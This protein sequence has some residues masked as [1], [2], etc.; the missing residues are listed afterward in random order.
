MSSAVGPELDTYDAPSEAVGVLRR[1]RLEDRPTYD[2]D[3]PA[4][5]IRAHF[6]DLTPG[7]L[8]LAGAAA[9]THHEV[10]QVA[11]L[12]LIC[13]DHTTCLTAITLPDGRVV[14][15]L[16]AHVARW[17]LRP[18]GFVHTEKTLTS[19]RL[20]EGREPLHT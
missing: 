5:Q 11:L 1:S 18:G 8:L 4:A 13:F 12:S 3:E 20:T 10:D 19:G 9:V 7:E 14:A 15:S 16:H 2:V 17:R 6:A